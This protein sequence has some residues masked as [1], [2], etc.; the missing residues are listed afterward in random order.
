MTGTGPKRAA[1]ALKPP[2]ARSIGWA[3]LQAARLH[4]ARMGERLAALGLF[5]G[6]EQVLQALA[7]GPM[8]TGDLARLLRVRPPTISKTVSRLAALGFV[9]RRAGAGDGRA[10]Q[11]GLTASGL[12]RAAAIG[13]L[14]QDVEDEAL[15]GLDAKDRKRLRRLLREVA[16][17]LA[18]VS[19]TSKLD[20]AGDIPD[21]SEISS[22]KSG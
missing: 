13:Q 1:K 4:R 12:E 11:V 16:R 15:R 20:E 9:E 21:P 17:N 14:W 2:G 3:L 10:V 5:A 22:L 6:Q 7:A 19:E 8:G 18:E